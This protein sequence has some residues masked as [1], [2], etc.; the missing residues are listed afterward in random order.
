MWKPGSCDIAAGTTQAGLLPVGFRNE[1]RRH[2]RLEGAG[3]N[4][5]R[6]VKILDHLANEEW[7]IIDRHETGPCW[8]GKG[9]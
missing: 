2:V 1:I 6:V 3:S 8:P 5:Y 7:S 9:E 4:R